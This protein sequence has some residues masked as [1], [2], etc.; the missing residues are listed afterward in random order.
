M[1]D[2]SGRLLDVN[3]VRITVMRADFTVCKVTLMSV[4][5][6]AEYIDLSGA[7]GREP[8]ESGSGG[9][10][11]NVVVTGAAGFIGSH[12][13]DALLAAGHRVVGID[14]F[15][16]WYSPACRARNIEA[17]CAH[18]HFRLEVKD[19]RTANLSRLFEGART[20]YHLAAR[21]GVQH[22]WGAGLSQTIEMNV[23]VTALVLDA[24][25]AAGVQRVVL[26]SSSSIYGDT[27]VDGGTR[28]SAPLSPYGVSKAACENLA[29]VY[30]QRGLD[31]VTLRYFTVFGP[32]QR[33]DMAM[34]R[35]FEATRR[36]GPA[37][38]RRGSGEQ[39]REFTFVG[40]AVAAT[41]QAGSVA[42]ARSQ[43][44]DIGGGCTV[45]LNGVIA[46]VG[47][48]AGARVR[49]RSAPAPA[50]EPWTTVAANEAAQTVLRWRPRA[51]LRY[52][53]CAQWAWHQGIRLDPQQR[54][55]ATA[56]PTRTP[57]HSQ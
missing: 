20:V 19:L 18:P 40:D 51:S 44:F 22:S 7:S 15:D 28:D 55:A 12:L 54:N 46:A 11:V 36:C 1:L 45:S 56:L 49:I 6:R 23:S 39:S 2:E 5:E 37:F 47:R 27:A 57:A 48:I 25:V 14:S 29:N 24:A 33:P 13:V 9:A 41:V 30:V 8:H 10:K 31:V 21:P 3:P 53:L 4:I 50:G 17:A 43:T 38:E 52:A 32:R 26:A 16:P 42:E 34:H 35:M